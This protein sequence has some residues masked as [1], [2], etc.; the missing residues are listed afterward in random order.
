MRVLKAALAVAVVFGLAASAS[1]Q[2]LGELAAQEKQK[3]HGK[4]T[5]KTITESD[6]AK[7]GK[8]GTLSVTGSPEP[9]D[10][11]SQA[12]GDGSAPAPDAA[13][14]DV[15][16]PPEGATEAPAEDAPLQ[17]QKAPEPPKPKG[18]PP[19]S[20]EELRAEARANQQKMLDAARTNLANH[21]A[22]LDK[23]SAVLAGSATAGSYSQDRADMF[24]KQ[25]EEKAAVA[26]FQAEVAQLEEDIRRSAWPR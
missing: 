8:K 1:A 17:E 2:S 21:Q 12:P 14:A 15:A 13:A 26:K 7:T 22:L 23:I 11:A 4:T 9:A 18:P 20:D 6:L 16:A 10:A 24:K 19:K 5:P 3:R 25:D